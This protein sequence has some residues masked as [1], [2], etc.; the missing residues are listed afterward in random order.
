MCY[1]PRLNYYPSLTLTYIIGALTKSYIAIC[2]QKYSG[3]DMIQL[4]FQRPSSTDGTDVSNKV[5]CMMGEWTE[6]KLAYFHLDL[7]L[8]AKATVITVPSIYS[9]TDCRRRTWSLAHQHCESEPGG[10][11]GKKK[12]KQTIYYS[13]VSNR[14]AAHSTCLFQFTIL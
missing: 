7:K 2:M 13:V 10:D 5:N 6:T 1:G 4:Y 11:K 12:T 8:S 9:R 14:H 3:T